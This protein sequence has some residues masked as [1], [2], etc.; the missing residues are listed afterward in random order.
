MLLRKWKKKEEEK[1]RGHCAI[2][3]VLLRA[4]ARE[5][6]REH[7][8]SS[9]VILTPETKV[10]PVSDG[11]RSRQS[12]SAAWPWKLWSSCPLSTSHNAHVPSPLD[13][14]IWNKEPSELPT[15]RKPTHNK[16]GFRYVL[17]DDIPSYPACL[18]CRFDAA[19]YK[20]SAL[21]IRST[22]PFSFRI[23]KTKKKTNIVDLHVW[24]G[25]A[26][27]RQVIGVHCHGLLLRC[28]I[29][30]LIQGEWVHRTLVVKTTA[31]H[32]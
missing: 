19:S 12:T 27:G 29:L 25:E 8:K 31:K 6:E 5:R 3:I 13:V 15:C 26:A 30:V 22:D 4:R 20:Y 1:K 21:Y 23:Q 2:T 17:R 18:R 28:Q 14:R 7:S 32:K 9:D 24:V 16:Y 10:L 11:A